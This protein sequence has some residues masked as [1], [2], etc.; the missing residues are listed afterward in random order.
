MYISLKFINN[1]GKKQLSGGPCQVVLFCRV[2]LPTPIERI[3]S[4]RQTFF[5]VYGQPISFLL[6]LGNMADFQGSLHS[7]K[8]KTPVSRKTHGE[9]V[10]V[11]LT[12]QLTWTPTSSPRILVIPMGLHSIV[13]TAPRVPKVNYTSERRVHHWSLSSRG[14]LS[15]FCLPLSNSVTRHEKLLEASLPYYSHSP[16]DLGF[17]PYSSSPPA[18]NLQPCSL[19]LPTLVMSLHIFK[20]IMAKP[21]P[22]P[23]PLNWLAFF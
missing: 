19:I 3:F 9:R 6:Y 22:S 2:R 4:F 1:F 17:C 20:C 13:F 10:P 15:V 16:V 21:I 12:S 5:F 11:N 7:K 14:N 23:S 18:L 8:T